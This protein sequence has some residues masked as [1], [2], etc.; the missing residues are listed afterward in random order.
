MTPRRVDILVV[1]GGITGLGVARLA[2]RHGLTVALLERGDL[3]SGTSSVSSHMLH[4]GLRYLEQGR[5]GLVRE[6]LAERTA[7]AHMAPGLAH[8]RRF[9]VP[10]YRGT[11]LP[12]WRLRAGLALY[13]LLAGRRGLA[14]HTMVRAREVH[15]LEPALES[16][17]LSGAGLYSDV[18]MD[19]A[20]LAVLVA[21]DAAAHGAALHTYAEPTGVRPGAEGTVTVEARDALDGTR[22]AFEAR[23]V[24][25][26]T[27]PWADGVRAFL[28]AGL[29]PG[30]PPAPLLRPSRGVH[31]VYPPLTHGHG[32]LLIARHDR[33]ALFVVPLPG[34]ALVGTTEIEVPSP[35]PPAAWA[36][37]PAEIAYL[38]AELAR[39]LPGAAGL[40]PLAAISGVRP[41]L[42]GSGA[43]GTA[44]REHR[45]I[46]DGPVLTV[47]GGKYT[48]FRVMA[49]DAVKHVLR[50]LG[51]PAHELRDPDDAL[52]PPPAAGLALEHVVD[53]ALDTEHARRVDDVLRRRT[54][55]W[56]D[57]PRARA[58]APRI[59]GHMARR[60]GW[61]A[62]RERDELQ[63]A[64]AARAAEALAPGPPQERP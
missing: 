57:P 30:P 26:A 1:G 9:L 19:D 63:T 3:A 52:P 62:E 21:R 58:A 55:L 6:A 17:D 2:A 4:G 18:V 24:V 48:T 11:R 60:L 14:P 50:V 32:L 36:P 49:R 59:A 20:R 22:L 13:D 27:G 25:N 34:H 51:R 8:P 28:L 29:R 33:R 40:E 5:I 56:L 39:A 7:V 37:D 42:A 44:S 15:A 53:F 64:L 23:S 45:V 47:A 38:R 12:L 10:V 41:L 54:T 46:A 16:A 61:S 35:P 31:L 43:V